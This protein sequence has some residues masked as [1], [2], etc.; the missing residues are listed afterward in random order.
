MKKLL[1]VFLLLGFQSQA[2]PNNIFQDS[3]FTLSV[4]EQSQYIMSWYNDG[5]K[6]SSE[7]VKIN[8]SLDEVQELSKQLTYLANTNSTVSIVTSKY[9][10]VKDTEFNSNAVYFY[11]GEDFP[12]YKEFPISTINKFNKV[13]K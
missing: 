1:L 11:V 2:Q 4:N 13:I 7:E 6:C 9:K 8:M 10:L 12:L 5:F 3:I